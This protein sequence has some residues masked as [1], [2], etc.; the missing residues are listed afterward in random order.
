LS[1]EELTEVHLL[2]LG[3]H[4]ERIAALLPIKELVAVLLLIAE[5]QVELIVE[6]L[7]V[8]Q[9]L[10]VQ[11]EELVAVLL[12]GRNLGRLFLYLQVMIGNFHLV[13]QTS[14][15]LQYSLDM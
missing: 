11:V 13:P 10:P 15:K 1:L 2:A 9:S 8:L 14:S 3:Q 5:Q 4:V 12:E 6:Q 7:R